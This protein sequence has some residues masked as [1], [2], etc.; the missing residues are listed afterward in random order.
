MSDE[1]PVYDFADHETQVRSAPDSPKRAPA[2]PVDGWQAYQMWL[3]MLRND[4]WMEE[5]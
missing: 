5:F 2:A 4:F 1:G 3:E